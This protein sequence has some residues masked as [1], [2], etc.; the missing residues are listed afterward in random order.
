MATKLKTS[1]VDICEVEFVERTQG[2]KGSEGN[3]VG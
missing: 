3:E 1:E 2:K